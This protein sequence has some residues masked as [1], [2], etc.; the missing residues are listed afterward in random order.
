MVHALI[1]SGSGSVQQPT[2]GSALGMPVVG[3]PFGNGEA[4]FG[5]T[6]GR[7]QHLLEGAPAEALE[8]FLPAPDRPRDRDRQYAVDRHSGARSPTA[9]VPPVTERIEV[10]DGGAGG[11]LAAR[12]QHVQLAF[13][14]DIDHREQIAA[15]ADH[16]RFDHVQHRGRGD[17]R[18]D[19]VAAASQ[20]FQSGLCRERLAGHDDAMLGHQLGAPL[21]RPSLGAIA[22]CAG[23][24]GRLGCL[25]AGRQRGRRLRQRAVCARDQKHPC[26]AT[27]EV[28]H[29]LT[30]TSR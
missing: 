28:F 14:G 18:I 4:V 29:A 20:Y 5:V 13:P 1:E 19:G 17:G 22:A 27:N 11:R 15:D 7:L 21:A 9:R 10:L 3:D 25:A 24:E 12:V 2:S 30:P 26:K 16:H 23:A 8:H 6:R